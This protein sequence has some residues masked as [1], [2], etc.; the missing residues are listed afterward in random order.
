MWILFIL[1][2]IIGAVLCSIPEAV[3]LVSDWSYLWSSAEAHPQRVMAV[4]FVT[5]FLI[6]S[7]LTARSIGESES[8]AGE[9]PS[10]YDSAQAKTYVKWISTEEYD[11]QCEEVTKQQL[12][13]LKSSWAFR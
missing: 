13:E 10:A 8:T 4:T 9:D 1:S 3:S 7:V 5:A 2:I 6:V 11:R 12:D